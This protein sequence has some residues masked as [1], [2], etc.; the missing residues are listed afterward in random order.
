MSGPGS[1]RSA[2][3]ATDS[4]RAETTKQFAGKEPLGSGHVDA[5]SYKIKDLKDEND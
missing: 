4:E 3:A 1:A 2:P 5:E